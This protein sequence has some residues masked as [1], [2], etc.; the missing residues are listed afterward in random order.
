MER[1]GQAVQG[2][3]S[4]QWV[5]IW[6]LGERRRDNRRA[7]TLGYVGAQCGEQG[8]ATGCVEIQAGPL[9]FVGGWVVG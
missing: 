7:P 4:Q 6:C 3:V 9:A 1:D 2:W 8:E 5:S